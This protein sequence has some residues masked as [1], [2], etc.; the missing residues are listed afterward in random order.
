VKVATTAALLLLVGCA[1]AP[2]RPALPPPPAPAR[3]PVSVPDA[4]PRV[5]ARS[6]H[7]NPAFYDVAGQR[8]VVLADAAGFV[9]RGV[10]SWYGPDFHGKNTSSGESYDMY[11]MT[12]AHRTLP[13]PCYARV[14]NLQNG[15]SVIVRVNDRGPFVANRIVDL[16]YTA[17]ARLDMIRNGTAFVEL[18]VITP[19]AS[20]IGAPLT[21]QAASLPPASAG[22][23]IFVQVG[24]FADEANARRA[25]ERLTAA[26]IGPAQLSRDAGATRSV[27]RV[28]IGPL[29]NVGEYDRLLARLAPLGFRDARLASD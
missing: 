10:A 16:S 27:T 20:S 28:R 21:A 11:A 19:D 25:L 24:A 3:E 12:A 29:A 8:Y 15:R 1:S 13:L 5:E 17:A 4:V 2:R 6:A 22:S 26:G 7:G 14:T 9:E 18:Q 23:S